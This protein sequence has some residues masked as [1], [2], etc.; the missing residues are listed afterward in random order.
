MI[1]S[2]DFVHVTFLLVTFFFFFLDFLLVTFLYLC[3]FTLF[4]FGFKI[5]FY[6]W[7][8]A[9]FDVPKEVSAS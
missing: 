2:I 3:F 8:V 6:L 4:S 9:V 1:F 5:F 7:M